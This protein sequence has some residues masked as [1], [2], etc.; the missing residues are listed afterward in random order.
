MSRLRSLLLTAL[1]CAPVGGAAAATIEIDATRLFYSHY[2]IPGITPD[3]LESRSTVRA[4]EM[5]QGTYHFQIASGYYAD[6][7]FRVTAVGTVEYDEAYEPF[8]DGHGSSRLV[9]D[10]FEVTL[11]ARY[12]SNA[13][14]LMVVT[15]NEWVLHRTVRLV[16]ASHYR[17]Q[18]GSGIVGDFEFALD[19]HGRFQYNQGLDVTAGG[20]LGGRGT[21]T[22]QFLGYPLLIDTREGG[23]EFLLLNPIWGMPL[24]PAK[25]AYVSL[26]PAPRFMLQTRGGAMTIGE[27]SLDRSG[28]FG[29]AA[30]LDTYLALDRFHGLRRLRATRELP[31][32]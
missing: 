23:G 29:L 21:S 11:D 32:R 12:L 3:W 4:L 14:V 7:T 9:I 28:V 1:C 19:L 5:P 15:T 13:G 8:L 2:Q 22:M 6:F 10:G 25:V 30:G 17:V 26:L 20:F 18:Q 31:Q 16:P 27:F 24:Y